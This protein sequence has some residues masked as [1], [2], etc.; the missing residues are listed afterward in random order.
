MDVVR[1][2]LPRSLANDLLE[3]GDAVLSTSS[4]GVV[5]DVVDLVLEGAD[6]GSNVVTIVIA[7]R[8]LP[9]L[10]RRVIDR[11]GQREK[12]V[13]PARLV[14]TRGREETVI[15]LPDG[16]ALEEAVTVVTQALSPGEPEPDDSSGSSV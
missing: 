15:D 7:V 9:K 12:V 3:D 6:A 10:S 14:V 11:I 4:R 13:Q 8:A 1:I 5:T 2:R 16:M